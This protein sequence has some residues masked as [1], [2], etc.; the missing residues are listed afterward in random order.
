MKKMPLII[1]LLMS[2]CTAAPLMAC[3]YN[4]GVI[5]VDMPYV[6]APVPGHNMTAAFLMVSNTGEQDC[7][8]TAASS[9]YAEKIEFHTHQHSGGM[10]RMRQVDNVNVAAGER[11]AFK[12]GGLHLMLFG[13]KPSISSSVDINITTDKCGEFH[14]SAPLKS[15]KSQP[16]KTMHH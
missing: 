1:I 16:A 13:L 5:E 14:F 9:S 2:V 15:L 6:R 10:M 8:L 11:V 3:D 7:K 4:K 12:P